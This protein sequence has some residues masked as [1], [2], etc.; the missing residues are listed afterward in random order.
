MVSL[1]K[2]EQAIWQHSI[3]GKPV[4]KFSLAV[5]QGK[6]KDTL[7]LT[8]T[9]W[10]EL[11]ERMNEYLYKGAQVFVQGRLQISTYTDKNQVERQA[12]EIIASN[13]QLLDKKAESTHEHEEA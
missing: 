12:I 6:G 4:T 8:I 10:S 9:C 7:W 1:Q 5:D 11:A 3:N 13:I 2:E